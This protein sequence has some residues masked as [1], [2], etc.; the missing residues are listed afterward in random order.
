MVSPFRLAFE[1]ASSAKFINEM[2]TW[3]ELAYAY[4]FHH[5]STHTCIAGLPVWAQRDLSTM[6]SSSAQQ[7]QQQQQQQRSLEQLAA[8]ESG[9]ALWD[10]MQ[11]SLVDAGELHNNARMTWGKAI[12]QWSV[13]G[14]D[15]LAKLVYL[16]D[17]YAL[18]GQA[19]PS[20]GGLLW[21]LGLFT[22]GPTIEGRS[23]SAQ[24]A[25]LDA[26]KL[27]ER[28]AVLARFRPVA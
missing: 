19:P 7:Q 2:Q 17:H 6:T 11:R 18:D 14:E 21:C 16:N 4:V 15:A 23:L 27:N 25:R 12:L 3:R 1:G 8:C 13:S 9:N 5:P 24:A 20:Y 10:A 26:V 28:T 22:G